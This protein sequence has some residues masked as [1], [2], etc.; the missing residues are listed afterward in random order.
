[1]KRWIRHRMAHRVYVHTT[2]DRT[3]EGVIVSEWRDGLSLGDAR[4]H[5]SSG[6]VSMAGEVFIPREKVLFIQRP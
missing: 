4:Y 2:D 1:M 5:E 6:A 3:I